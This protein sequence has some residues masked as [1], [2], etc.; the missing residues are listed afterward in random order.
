MVKKKITY[1]AKT[2]GLKFEGEDDIWYNP[3]PDVKKYAT[4]ELVGCEVEVTISENNIVTFLSK[5]APAQG[6]KSVAN[7]TG[8]D[9]SEKRKIRSMAIAYA[10]DLIVAER[11]PKDNLLNAAETIFNY[12][13][14]G[15]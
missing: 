5:T 3:S 4:K 10:K 11:V 1:V 14:S 15:K 6:Q 8:G 7:F 12:I 2:G 9:E 13:W